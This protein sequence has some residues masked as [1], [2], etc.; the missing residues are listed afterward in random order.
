MSGK[1]ISG[2][3]EARAA[4]ARP[5]RAARGW[6]QLLAVRELG[7]LIALGVLVALF[8]FL[9]PAFLTLDTFGD[10]LTQAAEL[11]VA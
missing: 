11:G 4:E 2:G 1:A 6:R 9:Q 3:A 8:T 5:P 10:I 7:V